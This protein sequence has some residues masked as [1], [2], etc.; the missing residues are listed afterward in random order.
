MTPLLGLLGYAG[1]GKDTVAEFL[2]DHHGYTR[3]AF[4][5]PL[6]QLARHIG[7]NGRKDHAGRVLL[8]DLG[9]GVREFIGQ[10]TWV[11]IGM[12]KAADTPGPVVITDV[13]F[14]N[15]A[16]RIVEAGGCLVRVDRKGVGPANGHVSEV[17]WADIPVHHVISNDADLG[18]LRDAV[19]VIASLEVHRTGA[20]QL[21]QR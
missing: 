14:S 6:K 11:D 19:R 9:V 5:D 3:V 18:Y 10:D 20:H 16:L 12:R 21:M 2:V 1:A 7:W 4:A 15:E 13:R 8:Q 17:G